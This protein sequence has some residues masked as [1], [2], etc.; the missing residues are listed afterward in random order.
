MDSQNQPLSGA[1]TPHESVSPDP[2]PS[3]AEA[4]RQNAAQ[5]YTAPQKWLLLA[6]IGLGV[7]FR[8]LW[9]TV[10]PW[11]YSAFWGAYVALFL[12][13]QWPRAKQN[14]SAWLV[15]A[16]AGVIMVT[17]P[18]QAE[19]GDLGL[20]L[21]LGV[22]AIPC[23]LML[24]AVLVLYDIPIKREGMAIRGMITGF[25]V[26]PFASIARFFGAI[27]T[28]VTGTG[29]QKRQIK[30][31]L[32]GLA[33][34]LPLLVVVLA[35]LSQADESMNTLLFDLLKT[36]RIGE[37]IWAALIVLVT[38]MLVYSFFYGS[39]YRLPVLKPLP[40]GSW[41][42]ATLG[43]IEVLLLAAYALFLGLQ[44]SY[45]F[46]GMLPAA[47]TYS[48]YARAGFSELI[49][50]S[51]INF[52]LLALSVR[53]GEPQPVLRGLNWGVLVSNALLLASAALR[54]IMY[55]GAYGLTMRRI[56]PL[57]LMAFLA[58]LTV[59]TAVRLARERLPLARIAGIGFLL[60]YAALHV[61]DWG[62]IILAFNAAH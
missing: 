40:D 38:S 20:M 49:A 19:L 31:V 35:L 5:V 36:V 26:L 56:L 22:L 18:Y 25:F 12:I 34:G 50:V 46:G 61:P 39:R 59:L 54:L 13:W 17:L 48:M 44:F 47:Y 3:G 60:W 33:V 1:E 4:L 27:G 42:A 45:L 37:C 10:E 15:L 55:I 16:A 2:A 41:S 14:L 52:T 57:W 21:I 24:H 9:G 29:G 62:A 6:A 53:Y 43:V 8:V 23:L 58:A 30:Q 7:A 51:L 32:I 28:V 11:A